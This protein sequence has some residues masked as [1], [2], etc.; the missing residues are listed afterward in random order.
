MAQ[1]D[2]RPEKWFAPQ[3]PADERSFVGREPVLASLLRALR[4]EN[5]AALLG[6]G[7]AGKTSLL[8]ALERALPATGAGPVVYLRVERG[9]TPLSVGQAVIDAVA[10]AWG[11]SEQDRRGASSFSGSGQLKEAFDAL[12]NVAPGAGFPIVLLDDAHRLSSEARANLWSTLN[13]LVEHRNAAFLIAGRP[14]LWEEAHGEASVFW[15]LLQ[16]KPTLDPFTLEETR[17]L[18]DRAM[19]LGLDVSPGAA[20]AAHRESKG[21]PYA[22]CQVLYRHALD[23]M[24]LTPESVERVGNLPEVRKAI[25]DRQREAPPRSAARGELSALSPRPRRI[26]LHYAPGD[27]KLAEELR[28]HLA[29]LKRQAR[30]SEL[31]DIL[32]GNE[33]AAETRALVTS[34]DI[35]LALLSASYIAS[36]ECQDLLAFAQ[37]RAKLGGARVVP[38][39][40]RP[41]SWELTPLGD[42]QLLPKEGRSVMEWETRD[43]AWQSV[44]S[45]I[46][47]LLTAP[48]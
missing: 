14:P 41:L 21:D 30:V 25:L 22:L 43:A 24:S 34:A 39:L 5:S 19:A 35:M 3:R 13:R 7:G 46:L 48:T 29:A 42:L 36:E 27:A 15:D 2:L 6:R 1:D 38:V 26:F 23:R 45:D 10:R 20:E 11:I 4:A 18:Y 47:K 17:A 9:D 12:A 32:P 16:P 28:N 40:V 44:V 33:R 31:M 37:Q 8:K